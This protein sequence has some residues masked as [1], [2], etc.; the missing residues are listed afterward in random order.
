MDD[1]SNDRTTTGTLQLGRASRGA[2]ETLDDTDWFA[3]NLVAGESYRFFLKG[4]WGEPG[5]SEVSQFLRAHA[6][7]LLAPDLTVVASYEGDAYPSRS[8][9][10][11]RS[12]DTGIYFF[13]VGGSIGS[14]SLELFEQAAETGHTRADA[15][16]LSLGEPILL[17]NDPRTAPDP[18]SPGTEARVP[19][20]DWLTIDLQAG[21]SYVVELMRSPFELSVFPRVSLD[22]TAP[23]GDT[24][25]QATSV[26]HPFEGHIFTA[27]ETGTYSIQ[28]TGSTYHS[29]QAYRLA[30]YA[31]LDIEGTA[32]NDWLTV[33]GDLDKRIISISGGAGQDMISF[34]AHNMQNGHERGVTVNL[35]T[36]RIAA[37]NRGPVNFE[38]QGIEH[39]TGS[40]FADSLHGHDGA[41]RLRGLSG[42]DTFFGSSG[43]DR[44]DGGSGVDVM[45]FGEAT[46]A[47]SASLLRGR[48]WAGDAA[49]DRYTGIETLS[50]SRQNDILWG[51][52]GDNELHGSYGD[53]T[54][55]GNGG[56]DEILAGHGH[57]VIVFSGNQANYVVQQ[58][59]IR[60]IVTDTVGGDGR[61]TILHA[62]VLRFADGDL[63]L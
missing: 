50:G 57:D 15:L 27:P 17:G 24:V 30:L 41:E 18:A 53:D 59:G 47:V 13:E 21:T 19:D 63:L 56:N 14:Y 11:Y 61:D 4:V 51:D 28:A 40:V 20:E 3:V 35:D 9:I 54:L 7:K 33:P 34:A 22:I 12:V 8:S 48:G 60:T 45:D 36:G 32:G 49:G 29:N 25:S 38:M 44:I 58:R 43:A 16:P 46:T 23:S 26:F 6:V 55:I 42:D 52:H 62:D 5:G 10:E 1:F 31:S 37:S 39:A 2:L